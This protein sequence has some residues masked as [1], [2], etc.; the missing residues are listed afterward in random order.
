MSA[1]RSPK[2]T[3]SEEDLERFPKLPARDYRWRAVQLEPICGSGERITILI[4]LTDETDG[5]VH[6][7]QAVDGTRLAPV[8]GAEAAARMDELI[9]LCADALRRHIGS[10][11]TL[12]RWHPPFEGVHLGRGSLCYANSETQALRMALMETA[13]LAR[14]PAG[15]HET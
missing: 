4:V 11:G 2:L 3:L 15:P 14:L 12:E 5:R 8:I 6:V 13:F 9:G 10:G 1:R 7:H